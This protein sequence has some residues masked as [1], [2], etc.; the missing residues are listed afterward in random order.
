MTILG[1]VSSTIEESMGRFLERILPHKKIIHMT[2][3]LKDELKHK[4][5]PEF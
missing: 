3:V 1:L 5:F 2:W 4:F